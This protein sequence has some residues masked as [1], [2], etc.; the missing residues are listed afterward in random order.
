VFGLPGLLRRIQE[1]FP[2][3]GGAPETPPLPHIPLI[4]ENKPYRRVWL[5]YVAA[6]LC[7]GLATWA[8]IRLGLPH[9]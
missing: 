5:R 1:K 9:G 6:A 3:K 7:G 2:E 8:W 4:W